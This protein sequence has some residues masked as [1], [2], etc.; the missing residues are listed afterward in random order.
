MLACQLLK[1]TLWFNVAAT[2]KTKATKHTS[3]DSHIWWIFPPSRYTWWS[4]VDHLLQI[5]L[6]TI[7]T[8]SISNINIV[9]MPPHLAYSMALAHQ[10]NDFNCLS[11]ESS[12][13]L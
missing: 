11:I 2:D 1:V 4:I 13:Q 3:P 12:N 8:C 5:Q 10:S 7:Y 9:T 6:V